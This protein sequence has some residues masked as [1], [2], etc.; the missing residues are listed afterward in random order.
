MSEDF[1]KTYCAPPPF[2]NP[3]PWIRFW[4]HSRGPQFRPLIPKPGGRSVFNS[5]WHSAKCHK[6]LQGRSF[7]LQ[8]ERLRCP[9]WQVVNDSWLGNS[10]RNTGVR[11]LHQSRMELKHS[12]MEWSTVERKLPVCESIGS[13]EQKASR[14]S[15]SYPLTFPH[16]QK[17]GR[18]FGPR[19]NFSS[20]QAY[21][22]PYKRF[23]SSQIGAVSPSRF[24]IE[25]FSAKGLT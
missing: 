21:K 16:H 14:R 9:G 24:R 19:V 22:R 6:H 15:I 8:W 20:P 17:Q 12:W 2:G 18:L 5:L 11:R 23:I 13:L 1:D 25:A 7:F 10:S 4:D 3:G